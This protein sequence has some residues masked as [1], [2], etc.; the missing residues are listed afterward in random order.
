MNTLG[1][2][3]SNT[4]LISIDNE[5]K[6][7]EWY[8]KKKHDF[9]RKIYTRLKFL[10]NVHSESSQYY[11]KM[12]KY[13]F[14]PSITITCLSGIASFLSTSE[15]IHHKTQNIFGIGVGVLSAISSLLQSVGSSFRYSAKEEAHRVAAEEYNKLSVKLK[16]EMEMPNEENFIEKLEADILEIQNKCNYFVPQFILDKYKKIIQ[17]KN[18]TLKPNE[19]TPLLCND[20][21]ITIVDTE[22]QDDTE[23]NNSL[24]INNNNI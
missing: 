20:T 7:P 21:K 17:D 11:G 12:E 3:D 18:N 16:F 2:N 9:Y 23:S 15:M 6:Y 10:I 22:I 1:D 4:S 24:N 8:N 19:D 13:I 5:Y 14:G